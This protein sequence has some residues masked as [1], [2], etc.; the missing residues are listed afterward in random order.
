M[1]ANA[2]QEQK[3]YPYSRENPSPD[4]N[5]LAEQYRL[6]HA[7]GQDGDWKKDVYPGKSLWPHIGFIKALCDKYGAKTVLDYG[8]GKGLQYTNLRVKV[9]K[10]KMYSGIEKYWGVK[11][12]CYD[13]GNPKFREFPKGTFDGVISTDV[14]EHIA[15]D[16]LRW[17]IGEMFAKADKFVFANIACYP[18]HTILPNGENAHA[19]IEPPDWWRGLIEGIAAGHPNVRYYFLATPDK[20]K[21]SVLITNDGEKINAPRVGA[22]PGNLWK[23]YFALVKQKLGR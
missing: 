19:T 22:L 13:A 23:A 16:D 18:A 4:Y 11:A 20:K 14:L 3:T 6:H 2:A 10:G 9:A 1:T 17:I 21:D 12:A 8:A 15:R 5:R 7:K